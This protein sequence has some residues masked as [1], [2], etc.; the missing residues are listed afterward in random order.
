MN[1]RQR[2]KAAKNATPKVG[3]LDDIMHPRHKVR[4]VTVRAT[5][6]ERRMAPTWMDVEPGTSL[7]DLLNSHGPLATRGQEPWKPAP[8]EIRWTVDVKPDEGYTITGRIEPEQE[9]P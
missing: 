7:M 2:K 6:A 1:K 3:T 8:G 9:T 5:R 4:V